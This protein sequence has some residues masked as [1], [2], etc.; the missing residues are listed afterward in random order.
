[1]A[2]DILLLCLIFSIY[3]AVHSWTAGSSFKVYIQHRF[4]AVYPFY[5]LFYTL[6]SLGSLWLA[7]VISPKPFLLIYELAYPYDLLIL[8]PKAAAAA[9]ILYTFRY[10]NGMRFLGITQSIKYIKTGDA[11]SAAEEPDDFT[12]KGPYIYSRHPLYMY[13]ILF[14]VFQPYVDLVYLLL[15]VIAILYFYIGSVYEERKLIVQFGEKYVKYKK[16]VPRIFP[17]DYF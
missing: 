12:E 15:T 10:F 2:V 3:A 8:I 6:F 13:S 14:L 9:G 7:W 4:P 16:R 1:M 5:R 17:W 11:A